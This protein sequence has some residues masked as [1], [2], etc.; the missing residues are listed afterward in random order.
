MTITRPI[1]AVPPYGYLQPYPYMGRERHDLCGPGAA[2][3][4]LRKEPDFRTFEGLG[5]GR[6]ACRPAS[7]SVRLFNAVSDHRASKVAETDVPGR[8]FRRKENGLPNSVRPWE[9]EIGQMPRT[10]GLAHKGIGVLV[11]PMTFR[12]GNFK[13]VGMP[14]IGV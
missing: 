9:G 4:A 6:P 12:P 3:R 11:V 5:Q 8:L 10:S 2:E 1:L 14:L 13:G 7:A